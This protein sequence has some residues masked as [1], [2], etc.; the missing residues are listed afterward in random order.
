MKAWEDLK[1]LGVKPYITLTSEIYIGKGWKMEKKHESE[2]IDLWFTFTKGE[3]FTK[4]TNYQYSI[5]ETLG[6]DAGEKLMYLNM[7]ERQLQ[8][9]LTYSDTSPERIKEMED[10]ISDKRLE[11]DKILLSFVNN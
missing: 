3:W 1:S 4:A 5:F 10:E 11:F 2:D 6:V 8:M 7:L 9:L